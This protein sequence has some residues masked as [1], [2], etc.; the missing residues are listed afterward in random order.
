M[1]RAT[2][3]LVLAAVLG[4][5]CQ[6]PQLNQQQIDSLS[7][8]VSQV[9]QIYDQLEPYLPAIQEAAQ[10]LLK[11]ETAEYAGEARGVDRS[12][13]WRAVRDR[14]AAAHPL[15]AFCGSPAVDVHHVNPV[16][17]FPARE[18]DPDNLIS[19]CRVHHFI[20]GHGGDW[21]GFNPDIHID[22]EIWRSFKSVKPMESKK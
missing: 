7:N 21:K 13:Q 1:K 11:D 4:G 17:L 16:H 10:Q 9:Q 15:C 2:L 18:L 22:M 5:G 6:L 19:L 14:Y 3:A 12:P 8:T 20:Y